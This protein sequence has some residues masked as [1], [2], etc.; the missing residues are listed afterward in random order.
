L[1][2]ALS[3]V[4]ATTL[5]AALVEFDRLPNGAWVRLPIVM[6][7]FGISAPTAWRWSKANRLPAPKKLGPGVTVWNVGQLRATLARA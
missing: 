3:K 5:P 4:H 7:I 1:P 6:A 2:T